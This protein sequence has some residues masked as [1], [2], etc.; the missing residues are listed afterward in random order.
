MS[1]YV[2]G[3]GLI[4]TLLLVLIVV[5]AV[6]AWTLDLVAQQRTFAFLLAAELVAFTMMVYVYYVEN[7]KELSRRWL[8]AGAMGLALLLLLGAAVLPN[9][10]SA[11]TA[12]SP[13]VSVQLFEGEISSTLYGFGYSSNS[14]TSPGP[15]LTFKVSDVVNV[16]VTNVGQLPHDWAIVNG[17]QSSSA[18][19]LFNAQIASPNSPLQHGQ[20]GSVVFTVTQAGN[21]YYICQVPGHENV[22]MWGNVIVNP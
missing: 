12:P 20:S 8:F 14:L 2:K 7:V 10:S 11:N 16:T 3:P 1:R 13:N 4:A 5:V 6:A 22:G 18:P 15:T 9:V 17:N 19:V 21:F